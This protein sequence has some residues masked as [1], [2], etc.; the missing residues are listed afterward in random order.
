MI[1][2][3]KANAAAAVAERDLAKLNLALQTALELGIDED[4]DFDAPKEAQKEL[5]H[6]AELCKG[7]VAAMS[8]LK[9][10]CKSKGGVKAKDI[11]PL[12]KAIAHV[13]GEGVPD[14]NKDVKDAGALV[15]K[16]NEQIKV[17]EALAKATALAK[18]PITAT[19]TGGEQLSALRAALD[20]ANELEMEPVNQ[21]QHLRCDPH[22]THKIFPRLSVRS[23]RM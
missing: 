18:Q 4:A 19:L 3:T 12:E 9:M 17:Q 2:E 20:R 21:T 22:T 1:A 23:L 10:T 5:E 13:K 15:G 16:A 11:A 7:L 6:E 8:T 14:D